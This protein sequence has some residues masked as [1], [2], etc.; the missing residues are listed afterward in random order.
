[1]MEEYNPDNNYSLAEQGLVGYWDWNIAERKEYISPSFKRMLGYEDYEIPDAPNAWMQLI[2]K[3]DIPLVL[4][5]YQ[6][7]VAS[8]GSFPYQYL[9]RYL[10]KEGRTVYLFCRG[11]VVSWDYKGHALRMIGCHIDITSAI[12]EDAAIKKINES[13]ATVLDI[14]KTGI[15]SWDLKTDKQYWS[16]ELYS[17]LGYQP[18]EIE[19]S[20]FNFIY[21]LLHPDDRMK[22][23]RSVE[24]ILKTNGPLHLM[25][26]LQCKDKSYTLFE[27][28]GKLFLD[29]DGSPAKITGSITERKNKGSRAEESEEYVALMDQTAKTVKAGAW[30]LELATG[31]MKVSRELYDIYELPVNTPLNLDIINQ[32]YS[33]DSRNELQVAVSDA[34]LNKKGYER[35]VH[36]DLPG[37]KAKWIRQVGKPILDKENNVTA[38]HVTVQ[39]ITLEKLREHEIEETHKLIT[40]QNKRLLTFAHTVSHNL[41][42][43]TG[44]IQMILE[45]LKQT[46]DEESRQHFLD[47]LDKLAK[48]MS[49]TLKHLNE[50]VKI[51]TEI[52]QARTT[53]YFKEVFLMVKDVLTPTINET[54]AII[55]DDFTACASIEYIPAYLESV[56]LNLVSNALKYRHPERKP[57]LIIK[58]YQEGDHKFMIVKDNGLGIDL[59]RYKSSL[60]GMN[61]TFHN[62]PD[63]R[64]IGLFITKHQVEALG[65]TI[66]VESELNVGS[67]FTVQFN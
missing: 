61:K 63:A 56:M 21:N 37:G 60:F 24:E 17:L 65:G 41:G 40:D 14:L 54:N 59:K 55:E 3:E 29:T 7:H 53:V 48:A 33:K 27:L 15:W 58:T 32:Y 28:L 44:N 36:I 11:R 6:K 30:E 5:I 51:Q 67:V 23:I 22:M 12:E 26:R 38:L 18:G 49:Q 13:V 2:F 25:I 20:N 64:G 62:N 45:I 47:N 52:Q 43:Y 50:V 35:E 8:K 57:H 39:D 46:E 4:N 9:A 66:S 10:H 19:A 34:L 1:M 42:S 16:D 31:N